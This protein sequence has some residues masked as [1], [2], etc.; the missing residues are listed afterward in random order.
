MSAAIHRSVFRASA[1]STGP[2]PQLG[3]L[4]EL[5]GTWMG[6]GYN[7]IFVPDHQE[8]KAFRPLLNATREVLSFSPIGA[9]IPNRGSAQDDILFVGLHYLQQVNDAVT[10]AA[11]HLEPG[12]WLNVP[13]TTAPP[14]KATV[15]RLATIPHGDSV[16][17]QG[18]GS[19]VT[20]GPHIAPVSPIPT[21]P[22]ANRPGYLDPYLT[23]ALPPGIPPAAKENP[24][25]VLTQAIQN[26]R[27][28]RTVVLE[29]STNPPPG[30]GILPGG[31]VN[32]PFVVTN[33][34]ATAVSAIFWIETVESANGHQFL[35]LQYT[36]TV[37][38]NFLGIDWPHISVAT[39][40]KR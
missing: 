38:L 32:I 29:V 28:V 18:V 25:V 7:L 35:Q 9:P 27:I 14:E 37:V 33:A 4:A 31:V 19:T 8:G 15:V 22:G 17:A 10:N 13:E 20:G 3:P 24:N 26:Q 23:A 2:A 39:L 5:P 34:N 36:Q 16:L 21:G 30:R 11:L 12:L 6:N 1:P 40:V